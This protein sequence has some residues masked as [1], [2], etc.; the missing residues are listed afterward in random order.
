MSIFGSLAPVC[1]SNAE[2]E[3]NDLYTWYSSIANLLPPLIKSSKSGSQQKQKA[4]KYCK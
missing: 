1:H 2:D 4:E 3:P